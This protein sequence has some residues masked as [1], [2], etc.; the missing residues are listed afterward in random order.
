MLERFV[1]VEQECPGNPG[2]LHHS[3]RKSR[4]VLENARGEIAEALAVEPSQ[5]TFVSG[6][7]EANN[8]VVRGCGDPSLPVLVAPVEHPSVLAAAEQ[9]GAAWWLV[10]SSGRAVVQAPANPV[11]LACMVHAQ[12]ETGILQPVEEAIVLARDLGVPLHVDLSQSLGRVPVAE[13]V[14]GADSL[15]IS[16]HKVGGLRGLAILIA[17]GSETLRPLLVGGNQEHGLRAGTSSPALA[18]ATALAVRLAIKECETR[19]TAMRKARERF[20]EALAPELLRRRLTNGNS[21][22]NTV[23]YLF[24]EVDGRSLLPALDL[25]GIEAS[26][27][28]ACSTGSPTPPRVLSAMGINED[29]ARRCVRFSFG[30][31]TTPEEA[32]RAGAI[33]S[34]VVHQLQSQVR[35]S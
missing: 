1:Q 34:K 25:A 16:S 22:P 23:M 12:N 7:T 18:A 24:D 6:G 30:W 5:V 10:D 3:G 20:E 21:L 19:A 33:V 2:S 11:G 28:S 17:R 35:N 26:Q 13:V 29:D 31:R 27:G 14:S 4:A 8:L 15:A 9:R 32:A